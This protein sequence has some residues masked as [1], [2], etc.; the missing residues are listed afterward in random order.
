[1]ARNYKLTQTGQAVQDDLNKIEGASIE[2]GVIHIGGN[3]ITPLTEETDPTVPAWA[4]AA[5]KP[6]YTADEVGALS[7]DT[8]LADLPD[9]ADHRTVSDAEKAA[10]D[11]KSDFSGDYP[12]LTNKPDLS[13]FI[14]RSVDDL[15]NY[16]LKNEVYTKDE[17]ADLLA[18]I[19]GGIWV[20]VSVLPQPSADTYG[21]KIYLVPSQNP[22]VQNQKDEY[23]TTRS[24]SAG[25]YSYAWEQI[26]TTAID[27]SEYVTNEDLQDALEDYVST[28]AFQQAMAGKADKDTD[29]VE[30]NFAAFD[31]SGN[32]V[33]SGHKHS[34]Y[35]TSHQD[36]SGKADKVSNPTSGNF[37]GLDANGNLTDS[38][39]KASDFATAAQGAKA[40][41]A[42]QKPSGGIPSTD[43]SEAVQTSLGK[44]DTALQ[45]FTETDPTVPSWAKAQNPPQEVFMAE[46][47]V[48]TYNA[49]TDAINAGK[50][51]LLSYQNRTYIYSAKSPTNA[52]TFNV[53]DGDID[54]RVALSSAG[55]WSNAY[56]SL[57]QKAN[58][59]S[60]IEANKTS[61]SK[62]PTTKGVADYVASK[63]LSDLAD[64][65]DTA[66]TD[67]QALL[68]DG[69]NEEWKPGTVQGGGGSVT[70]VT[71]G[72]TSVVN[73]QGVAEVPA[74]PEAVQAQEIEIDSAPTANSSNL[75]TSGGVASALAGKYTKPAG[76]IP[77][78]DLAD[79]ES[80][81]IIPVNLDTQ[82]VDPSITYQDI[83]DA[84]NAGKVLAFKT[85]FPPYLAYA[86]TVLS[87]TGA[88]ALFTIKGGISGNSVT[89]TMWALSASPS[90]ID[91]Q[92]Q[93]DQIEVPEISTD[94]NADATSDAK[95]A[96]P[97]A[98][99]TFVEG[100]GYG[101]YSKPSGGIP[102]SDLAPDVVPVIP[103]DTAIPSGGLDANVHYALGTLT[104]SVSITLDTTTEVTGQMNIY[105]LVFTAGATAPTITWPA[106]ITK[107]AG[108]CLDSTTLAPV[109]TGG[110][111]YEVSIVD[112]LAVITEFVA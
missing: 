46:Y 105:S 38:G 109:I 59:V 54:Y 92:I 101:T 22:A 85:S 17:V 75:V 24:G 49:V 50:I 73:Q 13:Q 79:P 80:V 76:G 48:T 25:N 5:E 111:T 97:K 18:G 88:I 90:G 103:I 70:D 42:Y 47:G 56:F 94:I 58:K 78:T 30:G 69:T 51:I 68:W 77:D 28:E 35:L 62:Y 16:Y 87:V 74:I 4:K 27:L 57:E 32:P 29:A 104:G 81:F 110:N 43:M 39:S 45:S 33:D 102:S 96:S 64:V 11:A 61:T 40:D 65:S 37:A 14:T 66:P 98:V 31:S 34:D 9:D 52:Y 100:K 84:Y 107:W 60:D 71:V 108:N 106:S 44:A 6:S 3:S 72:G 86:T 12:D 2:G 89:S 53:I 36:I 15:V 20:S 23:I 19:T 95:T 112:G 21:L 82:T 55:N 83:V 63:E 41:T 10:W 8:T 91:F 93:E 67:G 99:K 26:G 7:E 1:M